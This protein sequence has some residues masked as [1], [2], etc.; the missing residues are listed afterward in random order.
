MSKKVYI[1]CGAGFAGD[2]FDA[3]IPIVKQLSKINAPKYLM[4]EVLAE[5]TLALAQQLK[6]K[7]SEEGYSPF[8]DSYITPILS[9]CLENN[10]KIIS[11]I[12]AANPMGA[13]KRIFEIAKKQKIRKPKIG[14]VIGDDLLAYMSDSEILESPT[15]EG[16]DF[17][18]NK[19]TAAN[20]YL[21][22]QPIADALEKGAD[23]VVVGRS[24]D[25]ALALG[26]LI[27]EYKWTENDLDL[28]ASGTICGHL[29]ECGAQVTGA[30][31][32]DPGYKDV[33]DL[34]NV[35]FP[36]AEVH[37][38]G[39]F[40]ITKPDGTGGLVN[41]ATVTEQ[42]LYETHDPS[43]Y[44][45]PDVTADMTGLILENDGINR[46]LVKGAKG[47]N[48]PK[49]LK[50]TICCDNGFMGEAEI[51]YAGPN[52]LARARLAG[53]IIDQRIQKLGIQG[54]M[55]I[56]IIGGGS[57]HYSLEETASYELPNNGDYRVRA[58]AIYPHKEQAQQMI[59]EV[60]SLY[61]SGPSAGGG[62]R[63]YVTPQSSTAS[64]LVDRSIVNPHIEVKLL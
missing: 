19:I 28:M 62:A 47:K 41:E 60:T 59:D 30:Y 35:G 22:A 42:L 57:V 14:V 43:S 51:S 20:V 17:S 52:A 8:L 6:T 10:I 18:N 27:Y 4:F 45:V 55:R 48:P 36:I 49:Q 1:G 34:A 61:C 13:A 44:L 39:T 9:D 23:I 16:L 32:A 2:R 24:V 37:E 50:A 64:I 38:D 63:S 54:P 26:P 58:S 40:V 7:N 31:F 15:M 33:P 21:G 29:L 46:I 25:S 11:N 12:G 3:S 53:E 5:R 56:E